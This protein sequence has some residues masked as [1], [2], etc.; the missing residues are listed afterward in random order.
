MAAEFGIGRCGQVPVGGG[1]G[2]GVVENAGEGVCGGA[3]QHAEGIEGIGVF[4]GQAVGQVPQALVADPLPQGEAGV[5][6]EG[7]GDIEVMVV[8][9]V[10]GG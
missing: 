1:I 6:V 5:V 8:V 10:A 9:V 4:A 2:A 3:P 7:V